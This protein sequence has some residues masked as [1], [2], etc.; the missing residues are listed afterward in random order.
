MFTVVFLKVFTAM[1]K[2]IHTRTQKQEAY[3]LQFTEADPRENLTA[4][5]L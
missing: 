1:S 2:W 5:K 3:L 4:A